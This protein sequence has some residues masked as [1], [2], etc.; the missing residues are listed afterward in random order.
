MTDTIHWLTPAE[1]ARRTGVSLRTIRRRIETGELK[2]YRHGPKL[3]RIDAAEV[4]RLLQPANVSA[5]ERAERALEEFLAAHKPWS[6]EKLARLGEL[7]GAP[8][9]DAA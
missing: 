9:R 7:L 2:A 4:D 1:A 6:P 3:L 5:D 8:P